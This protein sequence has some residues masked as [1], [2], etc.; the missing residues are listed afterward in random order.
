MDFLT[1]LI[2][3]A[4]FEDSGLGDLTSESILSRKH[5]GKGVIIAKESMVIAGIDV[6]HKVFKMLDH[7]F[8]ISSSFKDGDLVKQGDIVFQIK[9]NLINML[10][11]ER[12]ALNFMQRLSGIATYTRS[13]V[14]VL[15]DFNVRICD[16]RKTIPGFRSLEKAAVRAGGAFNHRI[17]LSD[18]ILIKDNHIAV[19]KGTCGAITHQARAVDLSMKINLDEQ[20]IA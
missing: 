2:S 19:A 4:L 10:K 9:G 16:T 11:G 13:F 5:C 7:D 6:A 12:V 18:S 1:K 14:N 15:K 3:L 17:S 20:V 8:K